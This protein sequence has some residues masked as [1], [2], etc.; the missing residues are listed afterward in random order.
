MKRLASLFILI[1]TLFSCATAENVDDFNEYA[2]MFGSL[3]MIDSLASKDGEYTV[4]NVSG[5]KISFKG[6]ERI[7]VQG[8]G[9]DFLAY[10]M[11]AVMTFEPNSKTFKENAGLVFAFY[12]LS[13]DGTQQTYNTAGGLTV[14]LMKDSNEFIFAIGK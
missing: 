10:C 6:N 11:S 8:D 5:C 7:F 3:P 12:L 2:V 4:Y 9:S 14:M 13:R 1:V